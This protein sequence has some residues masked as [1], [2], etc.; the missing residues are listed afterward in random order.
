MATSLY[1][2]ASPARAETRQS[3]LQIV[4]PDALKLLEIALAEPAPQ[5]R[6]GILGRCQYD[7][8][9]VADVV[10]RSRLLRAHLDLLK[11][12]GSSFQVLRLQDQIGAMVRSVLRA[13]HEPP[14]AQV[15]NQKRIP[16]EAPRVPPCKMPN[17]IPGRLPKF[18]SNHVQTIVFT[19]LS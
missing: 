1:H 6:V 9:L 7:Q 11:L 3:H 18:A 5:H 17:C 13:K 2:D 8:T 14:D 4:H 16:R 10:C 19:L 12:A 15:D